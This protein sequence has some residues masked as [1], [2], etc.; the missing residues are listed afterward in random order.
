MQRK[1]NLTFKNNHPFISCISKINNTFTDNAEDFGVVMLMYNLVEYSE[2]YYMTSGSL[3]NHYISGINDDVNENNDPRN[4]RINNN[5]TTTS[6]SFEY[7]TKVIG[8]TPT[9]NNT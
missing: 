2:N 1:K 4:C 7:N 8:N 5:K 9:K 3:W 6:K